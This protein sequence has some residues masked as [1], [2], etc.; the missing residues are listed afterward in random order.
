MLNARMIIYDFGT[1]A[2]KVAVFDEHINMLACV[3]DEF[4]YEYPKEGHVEIDAE[5]FWDT[6]ARLT[7][8]LSKR[9]KLDTV[10]YISFTSNAETIIA[11]DSNGR[12]L[13]KCMV[14]LDTR[15]KEQAAKLNKK[16]STDRYYEITGQLE[17]DVISPV[18]KIPWIKAN[19]PEVYHGTWKFLLL[20]GYIVYKM[21]GEAVTEPSI[22]SYS[23]CLDVQ[24]RCYSEEIL[25]A[26]A[27][28]KTKLPEIKE[29]NCEVGELSKNAALALGLKPGIKVLSG[30]LDQ[31]ASVIGAGNVSPGIFSE[32]T[33]TVLAIGVT[34]DTLTQEMRSRKLPTICHGINGK[35]M[36]LLYSPTAGIILK[37]FKDNFYGDLKGLSEDKDFDVYD[38]IS[39]EVAQTRINESLVLLP[40]FCG[41]ISPELNAKAKGELC[42]LDLSVTRAD[43]A[44]A[45]FEGIAFMLKENLEYLEDRGIAAKEIISLGGG[46]KS[47]TWLQIK[48]DVLQREVVVCENEE[49]TAIGCAVMTGVKAGYIAELSDIKNIVRRGKAYQP[50]EDADTYERKFN[51]YKKCYEKLLDLHI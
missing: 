7:K 19:E 36:I 3:S 39:K 38:Y 32:T 41:R 8:E 25:D 43:V 30:M 45:I 51:L 18:N 33:G 34:I 35:H 29:S 27:I 11:L 5:V 23:G 28:D 4:H 17:N 46:A 26:A 42:G 2:L 20:K 37:W 15:P 24:N 31:C 10:E 14:W 44:R 22:L 50:G 49:S 40:H 21:T 13:R 1:T 9:C 48:S 47:E 12:P 6:A 16:I